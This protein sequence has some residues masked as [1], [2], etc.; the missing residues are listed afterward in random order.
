MI[1]IGG[2]ALLRAAAKNFASVTVVCRP[3]DYDV[4]L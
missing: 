4:V 2:P 1:D 3:Q